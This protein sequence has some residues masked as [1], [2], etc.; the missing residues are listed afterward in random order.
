LQGLKYPLF[1]KSFSWGSNSTFFLKECLYSAFTIGITLGINLKARSTS[2]S[3]GDLGKYHDNLQENP[4]QLLVEFELN[5][6]KLRTSKKSLIIL[7]GS[8]DYTSNQSINKNPHITNMSH[9]IIK[10]CAL[11][12]ETIENIT[13][14]IYPNLLQIQ[15]QS[16]PP[17]TRLGHPMAI[18]LGNHMNKRTQLLNNVIHLKLCNINLHNVT[19]SNIPTP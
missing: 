18:F 1:N 5:H 2:V 11:T 17:C 13:L 6:M 19:L 3:G 10:E 14:R 4:Q 16:E 8:M 7:D 9:N 12:H 15:T